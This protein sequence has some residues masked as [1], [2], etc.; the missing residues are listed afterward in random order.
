MHCWS[1]FE[2]VLDPML[3]K[4]HPTVSHSRSDAFQV[5][6]GR[7]VPVLPTDRSVRARSTPLGL[8]LI[9]VSTGCLKPPGA[10]REKSPGAPDSS[11]E[12]GCGQPLGLSLVDAFPVHTGR[13]VPARPTVHPSVAAVNPLGLSLVDAFSVHTGRRVPACRTVHCMCMRSTPGES[14]GTP[15]S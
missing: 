15:D 3:E 12:C 10:H 2:S 11:S 1:P 14:P 8:S 4:F 6:T 5:H 9:P 13:R 7:R